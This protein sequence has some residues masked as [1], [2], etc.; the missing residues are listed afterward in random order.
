MMYSAQTF[1]TASPKGFTLIELIIVLIVVA[2]AMGIV[3][4]YTFDRGDVVAATV[5]QVIQRDLEYAQN[6]A[7]RRQVSVN[8]RFDVANNQYT[9]SDANGTMTNPMTGLPYQVK[10]A[11]TAGVQVLLKSVNF[12]SNSTGITFIATGEPLQYGTTNPVSTT[13]GAVVQYGNYSC[14]VKVSPVV[15][16]VS[17]VSGG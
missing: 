12:G 6:E 3:I 2:L 17:I 8:V 16:K 5:A 7:T 1:R 9:I 10:I 15:G 4:P 14:T 13:S 11:T